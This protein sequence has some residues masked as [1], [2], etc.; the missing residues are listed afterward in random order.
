M[1]TPLRP[2]H[3]ASLLCPLLLLLA[4]TNT[5]FASAPPPT[6]DTAETTC[7]VGARVH[8]VVAPPAWKT[9][10]FREG[11]IT[12]VRSGAPPDGVIVVDGRGAMLT[13]GL[14][15]AYSQLGLLEVHAVPDTRDATAETDHDVRASFRV[16]PGLNPFS[17]IV[18]VTRSGGV[19]AVISAPQGGMI[20]GQSVLWRLGSTL[21][22][23][24][25][26]N[27]SAYLVVH[28]DGRAIATD[29]RGRRLARLREVF[30]D[31]QQLRDRLE[32][33]EE[34]RMRTLAAHRLDLLALQPA[35]EGAQPVLFI[36]E[37]AT[38]VRTLLALSDE[39]GLRPAFLGAAE[40]WRV[41]DALA[42][43]EA[44][45]LVHPL[46]NLPGRFDQLGARDDN[47]A[48]LEAAGVRVIL[49]GGDTHNG[50]NLR[51]LAGN[52]VRAGMSAEGALRAITLHPAMLAGMED[53]IGS[54]A[55][56]R[57]ADLVLWSGDPFELSS[58]PV[59]VWVAGV[60]QDLTHRQD[61][62]RDRYLELTYD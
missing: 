8:A 48:I 17:S 37:Q 29:A 59:A 19:T 11:T 20:A 23:A 50:R 13:P 39:L 1:T 31:A 14:I 12:E 52:A 3:P 22:D 5:T 36:A 2:W 53:R 27:P 15:D 46:R 26:L 32:R 6:A 35:L 24:D 56:G 44:F 51:Y 62:L 40:G 25:V 38:D 58:R 7:I 34:N 47:A 41:A 9:V 60:P 33:F 10:C 45:A 21:P 42:E 54:I 43:A 30:D 49:T 61:R 4:A 18:P 55:P 16:A 57:D 28:H